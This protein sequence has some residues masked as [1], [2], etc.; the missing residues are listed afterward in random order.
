MIKPK[1]IVLSALAALPFLITVLE[2]FVIRPTVSIFPLPERSIYLF[3][4]T[5]VSLLL[6]AIASFVGN[7]YGLEM[8]KK[9]R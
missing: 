1:I 9:L 6:M 8:T 4:V 5:T 2:R 7:N 3:T